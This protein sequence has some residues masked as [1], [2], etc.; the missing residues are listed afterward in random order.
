MKY[1]TIPLFAI[2]LS[3]TGCAGV[4]SE[5]EC[6]ATTSDS[7]MTM[8]EANQKAKSVTDTSKAAPA[9]DVS[10][11][12]ANSSLPKIAPLSQATSIQDGQG[13]TVTQA[14]MTSMLKNSAGTAESIASK[15]LTTLSSCTVT[16][17]PKEAQVIAHRLSEGIAQLWV[18][19]YID[20]DDVLHQPGNV[21]FVVKPSSWQQIKSV[22]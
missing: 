13:G 16:S 14:D 22:N 15:P 2:V 19:P 11:N 5:F 8:E 7:C 9:A 10:L 21:I 6:N 3:L 1:L 12:L 4:N 20:A 17:C 18:A